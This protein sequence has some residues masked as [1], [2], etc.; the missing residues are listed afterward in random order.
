MADTSAASPQ[1]ERKVEAWPQPEADE[2]Y[3]LEGAAAVAYAL[4]SLT[5]RA[6]GAEW[7]LDR[8]WDGYHSVG[9]GGSRAWSESLE[10]ASEEMQD[11]LRAA[12]VL[13]AAGERRERVEN[14]AVAR[15]TLVLLAACDLVCVTPSLAMIALECER[16]GWK[17]GAVIAPCRYRKCGY[18]ADA[19][20]VP[21]FAWSSDRR[22]SAVV[23]GM[24]PHATKRHGQMDAEYLI[25]PADS[26][27]CSRDSAAGVLL[28]QARCQERV[29]ACVTWD[30]EEAASPLAWLKARIL[31][32]TAW[33]TEV[34]TYPE[35][36]LEV[37]DVLCDALDAYQEGAESNTKAMKGAAK[38]EAGASTL[39]N[40]A[41]MPCVSS[42]GNGDVLFEE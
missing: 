37:A 30:A 14:N 18:P 3:V 39:G 6:I 38:A 12:Q 35:Q 24:W 36:L 32:E 23:R 41:D 8:L 16:L 29:H 5:E 17:S 33:E 21:T 19:Q 7:E 11:A 15:L 4:V 10:A 42:E 13:A 31:V 40:W 9:D 25:I 28:E 22:P 20:W 34:Q 1:E 26:P 27:G 2:L